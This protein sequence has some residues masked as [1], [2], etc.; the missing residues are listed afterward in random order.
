M[1]LL[2]YYAM[3]GTETGHAATRTMD[4]GQYQGQY[5]YRA[6]RATRSPVLTL[7]NNELRVPPGNK[8]DVPTRLLRHVRYWHGKMPCVRPQCPVLTQRMALPDVIVAKGTKAIMSYMKYQHSDIPVRTSGYACTNIRVFWYQVIDTA[9][10]SRKVDLTSMGLTDFPNEVMTMSGI[11]DLKLTNNYLQRVPPEISE[12]VHLHRVQIS[13]NQLTSLPASIGLLPALNSLNLEGNQL[14]VLP[15]GIGNLSTLQALKLDYNVIQVRCV[16]KRA[17]GRTDTCVLPPEIAHMTA[18][19]DLSG[20]YRL[21]YA[22]RRWLCPTQYTTHP[23]VYVLRSFLCY[24]RPHLLRYL[25]HEHLCYLL[26][27]FCAALS[28]PSATLLPHTICYAFRDALRTPQYHHP[29][30]PPYAV[31]RA[32]VQQPDQ[33]TTARTVPVDLPT[34]AARISQPPLVVGGTEIAYACVLAVRLWYCDRVCALLRYAAVWYCDGVWCV[35]LCGC[36]V[37]KWRMVCATRRYQQPHAASEPSYGQLCSSMLRVCYAMSGTDL[38][39][40][41]VGIRTRYVMSGTDLAYAVLPDREPYPPTP[42]VGTNPP[43]V[44]RL[45]ALRDINVGGEGALSSYGRPMRCTVLTYLMAVS[46]YGRVMRCSVLTYTVRWYLPTDVLCDI[47][48]WKVVASYAILRTDMRY[49][50]TRHGFP[51]SGDRRTWA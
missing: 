9:P 23:F 43:M 17:H 48:Y 24:I 8:R 46:S 19:E 47:R 4:A 6:T 49:A 29:P 33:S 3:C 32:R 12:M 41:A 5:C 11:T 30:L 45:A 15:T 16:L 31:R 51:T 21:C 7:Q 37:L 22:L 36:L 42:S 2:R 44:W 40:G 25:L 28:T 26:Q 14:S 27:C 38:A 13:Y 39:R 34:P 50:P 35:L 18:L 20:T 10:A 1:L